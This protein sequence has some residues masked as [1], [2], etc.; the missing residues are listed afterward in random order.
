MG[1]KGSAVEGEIYGGFVNAFENLQVII[2]PRAPRGALWPLWELHK[3]VATEANRAIDDFIGPLINR[4]LD[5]KLHRGKGKSNADEGS[6]LDH[7]SDATDDNKVIRDE[8]S[9]HS[10]GQDDVSD[11]CA[12]SS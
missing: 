4:A 8:V 12:C 9:S 6:L 10:Q 7:M 5:A 2:P 11:N 1:P 3:E